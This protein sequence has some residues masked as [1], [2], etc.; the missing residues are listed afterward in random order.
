MT[1]S[2][3][4]AIG[5]L[6]TTSTLIATATGTTGNRLKEIVL[7]N[8]TASPVTYTIYVA[9]KSV[10][11]GTLAAQTTARFPFMMNLAASSLITGHAG[12]GSAINYFI[13]LDMV[14]P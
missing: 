2:Y 11:S 14:S 9:A 6:N 3:P 13:S 7:H 5:T 10:M 4:Q 1:L 8:S 12:T